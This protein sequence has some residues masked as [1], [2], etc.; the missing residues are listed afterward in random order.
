MCSNYALAD[1]AQ[2]GI[3]S[4]KTYIAELFDLF[5]GAKDREAKQIMCDASTGTHSKADRIIRLRGESMGGFGVVGGGFR[6]CGAV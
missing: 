4:V 2:I 1:I 5:D 3:V 6:R